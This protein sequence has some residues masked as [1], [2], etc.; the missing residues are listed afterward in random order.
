[1]TT[2]DADVAALKDL[3]DDYLSKPEART[4]PYG[5][6]QRLR[7]EDPVHQT[8]SGT[9]LISRHEDFNRVMRDDA[10]F[11]RALAVGKHVLVEDGP[12]RDIFTSR[13]LWRDK[14]DH[15]RL[16]RIISSSVT[17]AAVRRWEP[18][19]QQVVAE[20][21]D[22][23]A[24]RH[25]MDA[26]R[27]FAYPVAQR[28][29]CR[30][31]GMPYEDHV[32]HEKWMEH[33]MEPPAGVELAPYRAR[34]TEAMLEFADYLRGILDAR[35]QDREGDLIAV[36][37]AAE[38][39]GDRL[40]ETELVATCFSLI[41]AGHETTAAL[42]SMG[43]YQLLLEPSR[44]QALTASPELIPN[45]VEEALRFTGPSQVTMPRMAINDVQVGDKLIEA[46]DLVICM[47][48]S[49]N[50]DPDV[51]ERPEE[52]DLLRQ[53]N[54]HVAFGAGAHLCFGRNLALMEIRLAY[55]ELATRLPGLELVDPTPAWRMHPFLR[56]LKHLQV[57]W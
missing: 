38:D 44:F 5:F 14:P 30:L 49:S 39:E 8:S 25:E 19:I 42:I 15:T 36:L 53:P 41:A 31:M 35:R 45:A 52:F 33:L 6:F 28:T 17:P 4:C 34:A 37:L 48:E 22:D 9:W 29:I 20:L 57:R 1:M 40:S 26:V 10:N 27:D 18:W 2:T 11:S 3:A 32:L 7:E 47:H 51:F 56:G 54:N 46:G 50:R 13:M 21:V 12:A 55:A 24:P 43:L 16:R 23:L